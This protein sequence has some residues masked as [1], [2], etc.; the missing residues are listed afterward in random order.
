MTAAQVERIFQYFWAIKIHSLSGNKQYCKY[1]AN[2]QDS[3]LVNRISVIKICSMASNDT[4][5][6]KR[7]GRE[8]ESILLSNSYFLY[9]CFF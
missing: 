2:T 3:L 6:I 4:M 8:T 9:N 5:K 1:A 7:D